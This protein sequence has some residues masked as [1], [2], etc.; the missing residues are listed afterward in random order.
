MEI[1]RSTITDKTRSLKIVWTQDC[2]QDNDVYNFLNEPIEDSYFEDLTSYTYQNSFSEAFN[3][4]WL[5]GDKPFQTGIVDKRIIDLI[6]NTEIKNFCLGWH[7]CNV[8]PNETGLIIGKNG[9]EYINLET[10]G[11]GEYWI[12]GKSGKM[13]VMPKL[14]LHYINAHNYM[15]PVEVQN[16]ILEN[17]A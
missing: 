4:G 15:I 11:N 12:E 3:I 16:D 8:C 6:N 1:E 17:N 13:Y 2:T 14:I 9:G 7:T 5:R 10:T